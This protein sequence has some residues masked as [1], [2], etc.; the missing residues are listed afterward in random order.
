MEVGL[1]CVLR[2]VGSTGAGLQAGTCRMLGPKLAIKICR[3]LIADKKVGTLWE[4]E[5]QGDNGM[6]EGLGLQLGPCGR[7][8]HPIPCTWYILIWLLE[9]GDS[10]GF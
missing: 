4:P 3:R 9:P 5:G 10:L 1:D 8:S 7:K 2:T 6:N